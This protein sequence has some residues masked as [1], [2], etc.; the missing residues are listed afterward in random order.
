MNTDEVVRRIHVDNGGFCPA[1]TWMYESLAS[2]SGI[3]HACPELLAARTAQLRQAVSSSNSTASVQLRIRKLV[4]ETR[5][6]VCAAQRGIERE[7]ITALLAKRSAGGRTCASLCIPHL[8]LVLQAATDFDTARA[9]ILASAASLERAGEAMRRFALKF[10]A[11]RQGLASNEERNA[12][13]FGLGKLV[14]DRK[15]CG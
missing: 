13:A 6:A 7:E 3:C 14:G 11:V 5:C 15:M 9:F 1:H 12:H 10:D 2:P 4:S 8:L